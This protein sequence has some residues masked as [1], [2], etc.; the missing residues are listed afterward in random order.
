MFVWVSRTTLYS[1]LLIS[2]IGLFQQQADCVD[3]TFI[4]FMYSIQIIDIQYSNDQMLAVCCC[5]SLAVPR[6]DLAPFCTLSFR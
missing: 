4:S 6:G 5:A 1:T 2:S 3:N